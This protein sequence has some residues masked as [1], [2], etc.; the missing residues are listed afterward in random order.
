MLSAK[1]L[2]IVG[3]EKVGVTCIRRTFYMYCITTASLFSIEC[4]TDLLASGKEL[5]LTFLLMVVKS[6]KMHL[7]ILRSRSTL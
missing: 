6:V 5:K 7:H 1:F 2:Y 3:R 4:Y